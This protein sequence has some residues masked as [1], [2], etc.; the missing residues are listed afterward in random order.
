MIFSE[1][2]TE[3]ESQLLDDTGSLSAGKVNDDT[4][5]EDELFL[6]YV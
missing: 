5:D 2:A 3:R 6:W 1:R 4:D